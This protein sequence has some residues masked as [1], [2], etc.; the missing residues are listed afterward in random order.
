MITLTKKLLAIFTLVVLVV[1]CMAIPTMAA[2]LR[3]TLDAEKP[4]VIEA[5][6][7]LSDVT[8]NPEP[9]PKYWVNSDTPDNGDP[10]NIAENLSNG[11]LY[12]NTWISNG[13]IVKTYEFEVISPRACLYD[14]EFVANGPIDKYSDFS[15]Y[16]ND[17]LVGGVKQGTANVKTSY[18]FEDCDMRIYT[19]TAPLKE[20]S[21]MMSIVVSNRNARNA[22][23]M[24]Y[25]KFTPSGDVHPLAIAGFEDNTVNSSCFSLYF[26]KPITSAEG[27]AVTAQ[28]GTAKVTVDAENAYRVVI[29]D[30]AGRTTITVPAGFA[31]GREDGGLSEAYTAEAFAYPVTQFDNKS[32]AH[33]YTANTRT[34]SAHYG[35]LGGMWEKSDAGRV[36]KGYIAL[37]DGDKMVAVNQGN[38]NLP[39]TNSS[40]SVTH[41]K[42]VKFTTVK[43]FGFLEIDGE[44][45]PIGKASTR[46]W[47]GTSF[48]K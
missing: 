42:G 12:Y 26:N 31:G 10:I 22:G 4:T 25:I 33:T 36:I 35:A 24:D 34:V 32:Y 17:T 13:G 40:I 8:E 7:I 30:I 45:I 47:N 21:N 9:I 28:H 14:I 15:I 46:T 44:L 43:V 37:Y 23:A 16:A 18:T 29:K 5:E 20:G 41:D 48:V 1:S 39:T 27:I 3:W 2:D 11:Y 19:A 6:H 38:F